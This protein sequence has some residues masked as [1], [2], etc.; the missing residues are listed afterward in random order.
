MIFRNISPPYFLVRRHRQ[1]TQDG[2]RSLVIT[3]NVIIAS[4]CQVPMTIIPPCARSILMYYK[5][6]SGS[7]LHI[8]IFDRVDLVIRTLGGSILTKE[9]W[10]TENSDPEKM[11]PT[12]ASTRDFF[13]FLSCLQ[14]SLPVLTN[15]GIMVSP[16]G[17]F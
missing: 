17:I 14:F 11:H 4:T 15:S 16:I 8:F 13:N 7:G 3:C 10:K 12:W 5:H 9:G 6:N 1:K 2:S